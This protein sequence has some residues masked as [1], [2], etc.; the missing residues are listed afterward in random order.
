[1]TGWTRNELDRIGAAHEV[2]LTTFR[3]NG[4]PRKPVT[5]QPRSSTTTS[6]LPIAPSTRLSHPPRSSRG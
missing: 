6:M 4:M 5:M 3:S 2:E 1:M